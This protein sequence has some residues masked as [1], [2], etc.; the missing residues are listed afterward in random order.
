[1]RPRDYLLDRLPLTLG[2]AAAVGFLLLVVH[3][4]IAPLSWGDVAYVLL[5][6]AVTGAVLLYVDY[7]RQAPFRRAVA[8]RLAAG[9][10]AE[11]DA[12]PL[13]PAKSREQQAFADLLAADQRRALGALQR[14]RQNAEQHR[15]FVDLW[16][17]QMKT[18]LAVLE[19]TADQ[20]DDSET[21]R[22]VAEELD[23]LSEGLELMLTSARL[24]RFELDLKPVQ[25]DLTELARA[26]VN[27]L[28]ASWL[29]HGVYPSVAAPEGGVVVETDPK[30]LAVVLRQ[31]L[32]NAIKYSPSGARVTVEVAEL[33]SGARLSVVDDGMGIPQED[34]PRV[35]ERFFTGQNGRRT[36]A[37][38]GM[39]LYLAAEICRRLGHELAIETAVGEG[40]KFT[41]AV[42]PQGLHREVTVEAR[43]EVDEGQ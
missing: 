14:Y 4:G 24:E 25:V 37:S 21:W 27:A 30:W 20:Q 2:F 9:E 29:R 36:Q 13:P 43:S 39:G 5:L 7:R 17:H 15:T 18:P 32:T 12:A 6:S 42:R 28:K 19:L 11:Y 3:L 35:F 31:L 33:P 40:S 26:G 41:V 8:R 38:T 22:S 23:H 1:M 34:V 10:E 16:V